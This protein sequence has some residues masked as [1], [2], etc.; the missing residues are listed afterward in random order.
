MVK[1]PKDSYDCLMLTNDVACCDQAILSNCGK[2]QLCKNILIP[3]TDIVIVAFILRKAIKE[4]CWNH[5][6]HI[7][8]VTKAC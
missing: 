1:C 4:F 6:K 8:Y 2:W 5:F 7:C 3:E